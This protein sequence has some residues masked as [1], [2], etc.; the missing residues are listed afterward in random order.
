[1]PKNKVIQNQK[2]LI[3]AFGNLCNIQ[4][5]K[6]NTGDRHKIRTTLRRE[7][8]MLKLMKEVIPKKKYRPT[9]KQLK[10]LKTDIGRVRELEIAKEDALKFKLPVDRVERQLTKVTNEVTPHLSTKKRQ[11]LYEKLKLVQKLTRKLKKVP[12]TEILRTKEKFQVH[13]EKKRFSKTELHTLRILIK[14]ARYILEAMD[15]PDKRLIDFQDKLGKLH[16]IEVLEQK[17][18]RTPE[19][20]KAQKKIKVQILR[21]KNS[22]LRQTVI[23]LEK[24]SK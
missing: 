17:V 18:R 7:Q 20:Q 13:I 19:T 15:T 2:K 4:A 5:H 10:A 21:H 11:Q 12:V 6:L 9:M 16:D 3:K 22:I 1:M 8:V 24:I 14:K 23:H